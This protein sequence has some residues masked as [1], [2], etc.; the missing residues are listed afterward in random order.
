MSRRIVS[1]LTVFS[2]AAGLTVAAT[3]CSDNKSGAGGP[4]IKGGGVVDP[5]APGP[6]KRGGGPSAKGND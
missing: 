5:Q 1:L 6:V 2:V 3:G 4:S